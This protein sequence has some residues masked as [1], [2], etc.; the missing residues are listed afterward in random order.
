MSIILT[1]KASYLY[2]MDICFE[3]SLL[4]EALADSLSN[5]LEKGLQCV[6]NSFNFML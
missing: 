1:G 5:K 3:V 6:K 2:N 4:V